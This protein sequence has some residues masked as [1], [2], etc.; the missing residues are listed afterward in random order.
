VVVVGRYPVCGQNKEEEIVKA[1]RM[2]ILCAAMLTVGAGTAL[3]QAFQARIKLTCIT[4][5]NGAFVKTTITDK[6][7][8]AR[9]AQDHSVDPARLMLV[10]VAGDFAVVDIVSSNITCPVATFGGDIP[11]NVTLVVFSGVSSN[12]GKVASFTPF[13]SLGGS[14]LPA[15]FSGTLVATYTATITSNSASKVLLKGTIQ[16]GSVSNNAIFTGTISVGGK[17]FGLPPT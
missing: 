6:D 17:P 16:A 5:N 15:D 2:G 8:V 10:F 13:N 4:T 3:G 11:T 9:C 14:L 7:I 12:A 1:I